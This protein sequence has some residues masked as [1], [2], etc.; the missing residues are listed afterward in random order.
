MISTCAEGNFPSLSIREC[1]AKHLI[2]FPFKPPGLC[3]ASIPKEQHHHAIPALV[4]F[5]HRI[6]L[7]SRSCCQGLLEA[8]VLDVLLRFYLLD[9]FVP[10]PYHV[11][12]SDELVGYYE[13]RESQFPDIATRTIL[14]KL[15]VALNAPQVLVLHPLYTLLHNPT[16]QAGPAMM[17]W[18]AWSSIGDDIDLVVS[19]R[20]TLI[21][22]VLFDRP[23]HFGMNGLDDFFYFVWY[24]HVFDDRR[25][26]LTSFVVKQLRERFSH[27]A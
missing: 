13:K 15:I 18:T 3:W 7:V 24:V 6:S 9:F 5:F 10:P 11:N 4:A 25:T 8:R 16:A 12:S 1:D 19:E 27:L 22:L 23:G 26:T 2:R 14:D 17:R 20:L 21:V